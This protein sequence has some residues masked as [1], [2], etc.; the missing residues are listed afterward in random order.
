MVHFFVCL[1][2]R[3]FFFPSFVV[4]VVVFPHIAYPWVDLR[5]WEQ[6][7]VVVAKMYYSSHCLYIISTTGSY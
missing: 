1:L 6:H 5:C 7:T 2:F 4:I 3:C